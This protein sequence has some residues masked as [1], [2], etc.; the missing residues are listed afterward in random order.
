MRKAFIIGGGITGC[1]LA[2][3]LKNS[4]D[5][6][7]F[8]KQ[9]YLGGLLRT[10]KNLENIPYQKGPHILHT[11]QKWVLDLLNTFTQF[12]K[13]DYQVAINPL[14]DF[15]YYEF[16]FTTDTLNRMPWHWKES[17][18]LE[19]ESVNGADGQTIKDAIINFYGKTIYDIFYKDY[20]YR[21]F[22]LSGEEI[23]TS[24][25]YRSFLSS[26]KNNTNYYKENTYFPVNEGYN[27]IFEEMV[28]G[29]KV[30][31]NTTIDYSSFEKDDIII[32]TTRPDEFFNE[33]ELGY[34]KASFDVDSVLY[35]QTKPDT[36]IYP[37]Y[38]PFISM[39]QFGK[40]FSPQKYSDKNIIVKEILHKGDEEAYPIPKLENYEKVK[41]IK[42]KY[43]NVFY[44]GWQT[45]LKFSSIAD[46]ISEAANIASKIKHLKHI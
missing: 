13:V 6:T 8:E 43:N 44:A 22:G 16:P 4:F 36:I 10:F 9:P 11:N 1:S 32:L 35:S 27:K 24:A 30:E 29:V 31:L 3:M 20:I 37:N 18:K 21:W 33:S 34:V 25:W 7:L 40:Y 26:I 5:I 12:S 14:I 45:S 38:T 39:T 41:N 28:D 17:I 15:Q 2:Y 46:S 42:N 23:D 19:M